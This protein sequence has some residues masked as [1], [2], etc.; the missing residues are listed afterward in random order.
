MG[1]LSSLTNSTMQLL[2][3]KPFPADTISKVGI[4]S[5]TS[6]TKE[7]DKQAPLSQ[8]SIAST[9][10][11]DI[12]NS[13]ITTNANRQNN[14]PNGPDFSTRRL[15]DLAK[16]TVAAGIT[17]QIVLPLTYPFLASYPYGIKR[18]L[19][20]PKIKFTRSLADF[21][22]GGPKLWYTGFS[23][24]NK[25]IGL[26]YAL[27]WG[28]FG[29]L[30][31]M[32]GATNEKGKIQNP[33]TLLG[34]AWLAGAID[35]LMVRNAFAA[36]VGGFLHAANPKLPQNISSY[37]GLVDYCVQQFNTASPVAHAKVARQY[38]HAW[39][40]MGNIAVSMI[41]IDKL[42]LEEKH[43][44]KGRFLGVLMGTGLGVIASEHLDRIRVLSPAI[45]IESE[46]GTVLTR[47][48][49]LRQNLTG[50]PRTYLSTALKKTPLQLTR[51]LLQGIPRLELAYGPFFMLSYLG[52]SVAKQGID[53]TL[54]KLENIFSNSR[55]QST[56]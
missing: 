41:I 6:S 9:S 29:T 7:I 2:E 34:N 11:P 26:Q 30:N 48:E 10:A 43:G 25:K 20:E 32:T 1:P 13:F 5:P 38:H 27:K 47:K 44:E 56:L 18:G 22:N 16:T 36:Q 12:T 54:T 45:P 40:T 39:F 53:R 24:L 15:K 33:Y 3:L 19:S 46:N 28:A 51:N 37:Q 42:H 55:S 23:N 21:A 4:Q 31:M 8:L 52:V 49:V 14:T 35:A 50:S 17:A